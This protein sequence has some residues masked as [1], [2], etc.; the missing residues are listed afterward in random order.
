MLEFEDEHG[1]NSSIGVKYEWK[2]S[3]CTH[4]S[5]L[6][7]IADDC[8]KRIVGKTEWIVKA[9]NRKNIQVDEEG[10]TKRG[11]NPLSSMDKL[12]CWNVRGANNQQKQHLIKQFINV[13]RADF[14]G[15]LETRVKAPKLGILYS[16]VFEGWCFSSNIAWHSGGKIV[17]AWNPLRFIVDILRCSSQFMHL[18]IA[19]ID[20]VFSSYLTVVYA[21][22]NRDDRRILWKHICEISVQEEWCIMGDFNDVL[23][24]EERIGN[25]VRYY[26]DSAF[27]DCVHHCQLD[28]IKTSGNFF[29]WSNKQQG[30]DRIFSKIDRVLANQAWLNRYEFAEV[31]YLNEGIFDHSPGVITIH[32][33]ASTGKKPFKYFRMWRSHT[34]YE[35]LLRECWSRNLNGSPM[36]QL[37]SKLKQFKLMLK[38]L[39]KEGFNNLQA[40]VTRYQHELDGLQSEVHQQPLNST[41]LAQESEIRVKLIEAQ[42]NYASFLQQKAKS[43]WIQD[44]DANTAFFHS[45]IKQRLRQNRIISIE[46]EDG[47]RTHDPNHITAA[48]LEFYK[49]LLGSNVDNRRKVHPG[50]L[51]KGPRLSEE[52]KNLL[53]QEFSKEEVKAAVFSIPG[54][55]LPGPDGFSSFFYQDNWDYIGE[56]VSNAVLSFLE[57]EHFFGKGKLLSKEVVI[58]WDNVCLSKRRAWVL[59]DLKSGIGL[60]CNPRE[61]QEKQYVISAGYD[62]LKPQHDKVPWSR[63]VWARLN[64]PKHSV[65]LWLAVLNRLK[66][67]ERLAKFGMQIENRC[68]LCNDHSEDTHHLF[69]TCSFAGNCLQAAKKWLVWGMAANELPLILRWIRKAKIS[70]F[71]KNVLAAVIAGLVYSI[72]E[73]RNKL[74]WQNEQ[75]DCVKIM[76]AVRWNIKTR[77]TMFLPKK[78]S[79]KDRDWFYGL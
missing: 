63:E 15:L 6:G 30:G 62:L 7:H 26:P 21:S 41:L 50:V 79:C 17:I 78:L 64:I 34:K 36:F 68:R 2:P 52:Q 54:N 51:A 32:L 58:A 28:D 19:T 18:K 40:I 31:V 66:T 5:G 44:G 27:G 38:E 29:T 14:V 71:R 24:K 16:N 10:F 67:K 61:F 4:C 22:N 45:S 3:I 13:Q 48:F 55:K 9:D 72:W 46:L 23:A 77:V 74:E 1:W 11:E 35:S 53:L 60:L 69:F 39:N 75:P 12:I 70:K 42:K 56:E 37:V 57:S 73:A 47:S 76:E 25:K 59:K 33:I 8:R 43:A 20:G 65:I 49:K